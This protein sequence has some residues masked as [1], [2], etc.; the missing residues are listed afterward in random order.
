MSVHVLN[1]YIAYDVLTF[2]LVL[3]KLN[4]LPFFCE[5]F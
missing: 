5:M 2:K 3:H 1:I 4:N